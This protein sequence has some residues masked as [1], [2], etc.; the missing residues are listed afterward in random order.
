M[1]TINRVILM[2]HLGKEPRWGAL[3]NGV[4]ACSLVLATLVTNEDEVTGVAHSSTEWHRAVLEGKLAE[5]MRDRLAKGDGVYLEGQLK[6]RKWT[7]RAGVVRY[8]TEIRADTIQVFP[9]VNAQGS[10]VD[11]GALEAWVADYDIATARE[12]AGEAARAET[13]QRH[14]AGRRTSMSKAHGGH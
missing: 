13:L 4:P 1:G 8:L 14:R 3:A 10:V 6:T 9:K 11:G 2:G 12:K 7:D 5:D